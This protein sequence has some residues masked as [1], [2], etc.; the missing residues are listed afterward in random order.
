MRSF[1][2]SC[3]HLGHAARHPLPASFVRSRCACSSREIWA[4]ASS[5]PFVG[6][7]IRASSPGD[8]KVPLQGSRTRQGAESVPRS[9]RPAHSARRS[10]CRAGD[11]VE[12]ERQSHT[13]CT[14]GVSCRD[15]AAKLCRPEFDSDSR[16]LSFAELCSDNAI[17]ILTTGGR[18]VESHGPA[19][20]RRWPCSLQNR[21]RVNRRLRHVTSEL[22]LVYETADSRSP[23]TC[24]QCLPTA[25]R[26]PGETTA[27]LRT[28]WGAPSVTFESLLV[29]PLPY[30]AGI[31]QRRILDAICQT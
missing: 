26:G 9:H 29:H 8:I 20:A 1:V 30:I 7:G 5:R 10:A 31:F 2:P 3:A 13:I 6:R 15:H 11:T 17:G 23:D 25:R 21:L 12:V 24:I 16:Q 14:S 18:M 27:A 19:D 4:G 28:G 22:T